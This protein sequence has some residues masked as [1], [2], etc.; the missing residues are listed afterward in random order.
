MIISF[1]TLQKNDS[2]ILHLTNGGIDGLFIE[3]IELK[4]KKALKTYL[5]VLNGQ[6]VK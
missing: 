5:H 6:L 3:F 2:E 1:Q 4:R